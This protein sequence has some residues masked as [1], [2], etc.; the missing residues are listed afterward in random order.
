MNRQFPMLMIILHTTSVA[1]AHH[2]W[3]LPQQPDCETARVVFSDYLRPDKPEFLD[4]IA[5]T[6][7][8]SR[9]DAGREAA[10]SWRKDG[11][12]F[13]LDV[14]DP[15]IQTLGG[16]CIYG[17]ETYDH[18]EWKRVAPYLLVYYP[19]VMLSRAKDGTPWDKL[20]LEIVPTFAGNEVRLQVLFRGKPAP[21]AELFVHPLTGTR[22]SLRTN[23]QGV[24]QV[25]LKSEGLYGFRTRYLESKVGEHAKQDYGEVRH[26]ASLVLPVDKLPCVRLLPFAEPGPNLPAAASR[27]PQIA[28]IFLKILLSP[29]QP[30]TCVPPLSANLRSSPLKLNDPML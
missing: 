9:D 3:I 25:P 18:R 10:I 5:H 27:K 24:I 22:E 13:S 1:Q 20:A 21:Q 14:S 19:K 16:E 6:R 23:E 8:W 2:I 17:I 7:L 4:K 30:S 15:K 12:A 11:D 28:S 29:R 26:Y